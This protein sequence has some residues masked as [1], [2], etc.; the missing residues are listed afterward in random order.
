[1]K[2]T[3]LSIFAGIA[4][5][6]TISAQIP[7]AGFENWTT[8]NTYSIPDGW[9]TMNHTT[10][11]S[12]VFTA[13]KGT[14]GN[15]GT[16]YL[17][18]VSKTVG[19]SVVNGIAV[20]GILD[21]ITMEP[22]SGFAYSEQPVSFSGKY[23]HMISGSSQGSI[24]ALLTKW[25]VSTNKRDTIAIASQTL[26]GMAMSWS[27]FSL[28]FNYLSNLAP[29]S[30]III[31]KASGT[32]PANGDYLYVDNIAFSGSTT[33]IS[34]NESSFNDLI[35]FPNP[36]SGLLNLKISSASNQNIRFE[37]IDLT[38]KLILGENAVYSS[39][40]SIYSIDIEHIAKGTYLLKIS[41]DSQYDIRKI[42]IN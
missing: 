38:G 24:M 9:G 13:T 34:K 39:D 21:T 19:S 1:M 27:N 7:N 25:N 5:M 4:T 29:D 37:M 15:V 42:V 36:A 30:C 35:I 6:L 40:G 33:S 32:T 8:I 3:I 23:Q 10:A 11:S 22:I 20:S 12:S 26:S 18:L 41:N 28:D 2:K 16:A 17:K 31:L 14:P